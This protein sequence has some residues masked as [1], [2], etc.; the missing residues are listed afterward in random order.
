VLHT[1]KIRL[2]QTLRWC[3]LLSWLLLLSS[4][5]QYDLTLKFDHQ[6]HGQ[7]VQ[8]IT[9]ND[10]AAAVANGTL[11]PW[12]SSLEARTRQLGGTVTETGYHQRSLA[13]PFTTGEELVKRFNRLFADALPVDGVPNGAP[14]SAA[15]A[16]ILTVPGLGPILFH[17]TVEQANWVLAS[18]THL[19][20]DLDLQQ[21]PSVGAADRALDEDRRWSTLG[22][23]LQTPWGLGRV[24]PTSATPDLILPNGARWQLQPGQAYHIEVQ[25]WLPSLVSLGAV[26]IAIFVV[27]GYFLR[28]RVLQ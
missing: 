17:L 27:L 9:L 8:V 24:L 11:A 13:V 1:F 18:R 16:Q 26:G 22:F 25:F 2:Y 4:C 5:V 21:L 19:T 12:V 3:L 6:L 23:R 10:R 7:I 14:V 28:Y 20:Y 15:T